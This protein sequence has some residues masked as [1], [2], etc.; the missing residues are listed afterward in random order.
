MSDVAI[1]IDG[2]QEEHAPETAIHGAVFVD[3]SPNLVL[4]FRCPF[5]VLP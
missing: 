3:L 2:A 5:P 4:C 1:F